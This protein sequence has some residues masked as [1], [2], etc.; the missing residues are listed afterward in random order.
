MQLQE[1]FFD[2]VV[3]PAAQHVDIAGFE[4]CGLDRLVNDDVGLALVEDLRA[5]RPHIPG[6]VDGYR[7]HR[8]T[9][10]DGHPERPL[11]EGMQI[12]VAA[13]GPFG[14]DDQRVA[15]LLGFGDSLVDGGIGACSCAAI[16]LDHPGDVE[17]LGKHGNLVK[18]FLG[19]ISD[20]CRDRPEQQRDIKVGEMVGE[21]EVLR[22]GLDVFGAAHCVAHRWNQKEDP[23][24]Q[25]DN[26]LAEFAQSQG[27]CDYKYCRDDD[28]VKHEQRHSDRRLQ[29]EQDL[30][31]HR[32]S[33][34]HRLGGRRSDAEA[35]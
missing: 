24:P 31:R 25:L 13:P 15:V 34:V 1:L 4:V 17:R 18:L 3:D 14:K 8:K 12:S 5:G 33:V 22:I 11:L 16:N 28:R 6:A 7:N 19:E 9:G 26:G 32:G 29:A 30:S 10:S 23:A 27:H 35:K 20:R 2:D 21:E